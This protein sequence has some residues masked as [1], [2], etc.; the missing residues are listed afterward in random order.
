MSSAAEGASFSNSSASTVAVRT[1]P[2]GFE[3]NDI[4]YQR[5]V[6]HASGLYWVFY[7]DGK[8]YGFKTSQDGVSWLS[9]TILTT[10]ATKFSGE[11]AYFCSGSTLYYAASNGQAPGYPFFLYRYGNLTPGGTIDWKIP[12]WPSTRRDMTLIFPR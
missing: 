12:D 8:N 10:T 9:E 7:W 5:Q 3:P 11:A 6:C 2:N 1:T 4:D